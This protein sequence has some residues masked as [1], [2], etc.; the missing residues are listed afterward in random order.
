MI[1]DHRGEDEQYERAVV[2]VGKR[3]ARFVVVHHSV[4][5]RLGTDPLDRSHE[6]T[7]H[8]YACTGLGHERCVD[9][10]GECLEPIAR[11]LVVGCLVGPFE[12]LHRD[13]ALIETPEMEVRYIAPKESLFWRD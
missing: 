8:R 2:I 12:S 5:Q 9:R 4:A 1:L 7:L 11:G 10:L 6:L 3:F 13:G